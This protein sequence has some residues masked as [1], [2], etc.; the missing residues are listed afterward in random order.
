M[1]SPSSI[2]SGH[3]AFKL[4]KGELFLSHKQIQPFHT[5]ALIKVRYIHS[6]TQGGGTQPS[7]RKN[8]LQKRDVDCANRENFHRL[9]PKLVLDA[10]ICDGCNHNQCVSGMDRWT[11][12]QTDRRQIDW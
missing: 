8:L 10:S 9:A 7:A 4:G 2:G 1:K 6:R 11:D 12:R 5:K 3:H